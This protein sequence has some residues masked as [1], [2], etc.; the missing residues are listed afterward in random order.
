[1]NLCYTNSG[2]QHLSLFDCLEND[3]MISDRGW[4]GNRSK[5]CQ[6][7]EVNAT[8]VTSK[9]FPK[10]CSQW[11]IAS[12]YWFRNGNQTTY[13][14]VAI[15]C[16]DAGGMEW[17]AVAGMTFFVMFVLICLPIIATVYLHYF[18]ATKSPSEY[19]IIS[20]LL[21]CWDLRVSFT[22]LCEVRGGSGTIF[23]DAF[24]VFSMAWIIMGHNYSFSLLAYT[25]RGYALAQLAS[26]YNI[27]ADNNTSN[28]AVATFFWIGGY[29]G[30]T[31]ML[32]R[33]SSKTS[34]S[35][36][37]EHAKF[38]TK[39]Y[40][41]RYLRTVPMLLN[42]IVFAWV[43]IPRLGSGLNWGQYFHYLSPDHYDCEKNWWRDLL[44]INT[45]WM[46][47][48]LPWAW[49][50]TTDF[51]FALL[52]PILVVPFVYVSRKAGFSTSIVCMIAALLNTAYFESYV[53]ANSR[54]SSFIWGLILASV[55]DFLKE[56]EVN[57]SKL[58]GCQVVVANKEVDETLDNS[59]IPVVTDAS[60]FDVFSV[61]LFNNMVVRMTCYVLSGILLWYVIV[62]HHLVGRPGEGG[63]SAE[64]I[65]VHLVM[66]E[67]LWGLALNLLGIPFILGH[68]GIIRRALSH[69]FWCIAGKLTFGAYLSHPVIL[70]VCIALSPEVVYSKSFSY[71]E[72]WGVCVASYTAAV[73]LWHI[74][75]RPASA[76]VTL[77]GRSITFKVGVLIAAS[78]ILLLLVFGL[79]VSPHVGDIDPLKS[80][81]YHY[82]DSA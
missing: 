10:E 67:L 56:K 20:Q 22:D 41:N 12:W 27:I 58:K 1:M 64:R 60:I 39:G 5:W 54:A 40:F 81:I 68:G 35:G 36:L 47:F 55:V 76:I 38:F 45:Y 70:V 61:K 23:L 49:Y 80:P 15:R 16:S 65:R 11:D 26:R 7:S 17:T 62:S 82:E 66:R 52:L 21:C 32:R 9:C 44:F 42:C 50:I 8:G 69:P 6:L 28:L 53:K 75:E 77:I 18:T 51:H 74:I 24:R 63:F 29:L 25:N 34:P 33:L 30:T 37:L 19:N 48:C 78:G 43:I 59:E 57:E 2:L 72:W 46:G 3:F 4:S 14:S 13:E 71:I 73:F 31:S 79:V